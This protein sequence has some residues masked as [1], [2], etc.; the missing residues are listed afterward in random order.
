[1]NAVMQEFEVTAWKFHLSIFEAS[2]TP[3]PG[4][5]VKMLLR[6][7]ISKF[8]VRGCMRRMEKW[9]KS[10]KPWDSGVFCQESLECSV[11]NVRQDYIHITLFWWS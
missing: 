2:F 9:E 1:M 5:W 8:L 6:E 11:F 3:R 10:C 7:L 4:T